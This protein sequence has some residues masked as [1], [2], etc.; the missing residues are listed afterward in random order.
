VVGAERVQATESG[1]VLRHGDT[2]VILGRIGPA[3]GSSP[4]DTKDLYGPEVKSALLVTL[5][6]VITRGGLSGTER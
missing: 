1:Q 5:Y 4:S 6:F 2:S 3:Q